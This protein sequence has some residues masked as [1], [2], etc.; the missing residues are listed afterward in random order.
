MQRDS[1]TVKF[2]LKNVCGICLCGIWLSLKHFLKSDLPTYRN[3]GKI[4][5]KKFALL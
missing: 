2:L 3:S 1:S 4:F 5:L